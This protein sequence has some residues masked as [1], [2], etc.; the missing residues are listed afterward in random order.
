MRYVVQGTRIQDITVEVE[1]D[2]Q[3]EAIKKAGSGYA[4]DIEVWDTKFDWF[5]AVDKELF[6][7]Y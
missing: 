5:S 6:G 4:G 3:E 2:S 1:A 7:D